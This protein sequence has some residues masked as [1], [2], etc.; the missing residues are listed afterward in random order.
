MS[1]DTCAIDRRGA[2]RVRWRRFATIYASEVVLIRTWQSRLR[3]FACAAVV[4]ALLQF[5]LQPLALPPGLNRA[6]VIAGYSAVSSVLG[7]LLLF[8]SLVGGGWLAYRVAADRPLAG[9]QAAALGLL[10][11]VLPRGTVDEW[12]IYVHP[13][14]GKPRSFAYLVFLADYLV[15]AAAFASLWMIRQRVS[16]E[17]ARGEPSDRSSPLTERLTTLLAVTAIAAAL[18][19]VLNGP[20]A[21]GT[22]RGQVIF[23]V[24][25]GFAAPILAGRS[26]LGWR[27]VSVCLLAPWLVGVLGVIWGL[28]QPGLAPEYVRLGIIPVTPLVRPLPVEMVSIGILAILWASK[29]SLHAAEHPAS[30]QPSPG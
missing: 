26:F 13:E 21:M 23:A 16:T 6:P 11:W 15:L 7:G 18:M 19:L 25:V 2:I 12:L 20:R 4:W 9:M 17:P 28:V 24:A 8:L 1:F 29:P 3:L 5:L 14:L 30:P 22:H 10:A 27:D